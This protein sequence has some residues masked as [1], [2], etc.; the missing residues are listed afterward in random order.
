MKKSFMFLLM[1]FLLLIPGLALSKD[2]ITIAMGYIPNVQFA[3]YY[4]AMEKGYFEKEGLEVSFD[5]GMATDIMSLVANGVVDF[6]VSDGDQVI[7]A[8]E[9]KVPIKVVYSMYVKYPVGVVSLKK[10]G[11]TDI[12]S[13]KGKRVGTPAPYGSNYI[14]LQVLLN[15]YG[16]TLKDID[17]E[18]IGYTQ[19]ESILSER[20]E[21]SVVF[22]NNEV[23]VLKDMGK[24]VNVIEVYPIT[25]MVSAAI[26]TSDRLI[27]KNPD[28]VKRFVS[29]VTLASRYALT[30]Q[31]EVIDLL[32]GYIPTLTDKNID[33]NKKV[34]VESMKLWV[35]K[36][37]E[38]YGLGYTTRADW[39]SS[40]E[41]LYELG[42]IERM[43][44]AD[45]CFS[46]EFLIYGK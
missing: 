2:S 25:P 33:I 35:D 44:D 4:I 14:G 39:E 36:D 46:N 42:L 34:L 24:E 7:I 40:V 43:I 22:I 29:A 37:I 6:G 21:A 9:K 1:V 26:I 13:L 8:R 10:S 45:E 11:I 17:L 19:V 12:H 23:I 31:D 30:V 38:K 27:E 32:K 20:V 18:F 28:L 5:Y 15:R 16:Y 41:I 3:P